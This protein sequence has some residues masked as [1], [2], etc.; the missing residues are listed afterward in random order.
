M[1]SGSLV[2]AALV[3]GALLTAVG[4]GVSAAQDGPEFASKVPPKPL[5]YLEMRDFGGNLVKLMESKFA[6]DFL[7]SKAFKD[8]TVTKLYNKLADRINELKEATGF[9]LSVGSAREIAG[10][11]AALALYDIGE[12]RM[13]FLT[14]I[15]A[16]KLAA[17]A[18]WRMRRQ[19]EERA[20]D[21]VTYY[22]KEDPDGRVALAFAQVGDI[23]VAGTDVNRFEESLRLLTGEGE[24]LALDDK[25]KE[26]FPPEFELEDA[27][28]YLDQERISETPHFRS[29]WIFGNQGELRDVKQAA[30]S[31][32]F[33][34]SGITEIRRLLTARLPEPSLLGFAEL[35]RELPGGGDFY[36][37]GN[38]WEGGDFCSFLAAEL[39]ED[40]DKELAD[41]LL[42]ALAGSGPRIY[43]VAATAAFDKDEFFLT[44]GKTVVLS[45]NSPAALNRP[46]LEDA[47]AGYFARKLLHPGQ[48]ELKFKDGG[49]GFRVL[50]LPLFGDSVPGYAVKSGSLVMTNDAGALASGTE[51]LEAEHLEFLQDADRNGA[52]LLIYIDA[53]KS[54]S[55]LTEYFKIIS[56][57]DN[58]EYSGN[59]S[60][61][62]R[63]VISLLKTLEFVERIKVR[64][65]WVGTTLL[66]EISYV[67]KRQ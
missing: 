67:F 49:G 66:E 64:H 65:A 24:S 47:L 31:L 3:V 29:Y 21:G 57:R 61:F 19:F 10:G 36:V 40:A 11:P 6:D 15:P 34:D 56:Q 12:L 35:A 44:V 41:G 52:C 26:A 46:K 14:R 27:L 13:L 54:A 58:W 25:F 9:E 22:V 1:R 16:E 8:F 39:Y 48:G 50:D 53:V 32:R 30:I 4:V 23:L 45:L 51:D 43:G 18:L 59:A 62:W 38:A 33:A 37:Y 60:F 55:H 28:L 63:N 17:S 42:G 7:K 5:V 20:A 2:L